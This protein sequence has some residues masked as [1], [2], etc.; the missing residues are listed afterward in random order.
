M[1]PESEV[2]EYA[3]LLKNA[4][5]DANH[6]DEEAWRIA[7]VVHW[8]IRWILGEQELP[9]NAKMFLENLEK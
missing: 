2:R 4:L 3:E 5:D 6:S 8:H 1:I 7:H 9:T